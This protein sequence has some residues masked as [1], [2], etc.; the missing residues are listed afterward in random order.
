ME[1]DPKPVLLEG[2]HVRM[3]PLTPEH[4]AGLFAAA[5]LEVFRYLIIPP[6]GSVADADAYV[7]AAL[8]AQAKGTEVPFATVRR[9]DG[10]VVGTTRF[11]DI[12]R[13]HR[14]LE[15]GWTWITPAAQRTP[16][17]TEAK[18]LM[19][20]QAFDGWGALRVQL[21]TDENNARSRAAI[22]RIGAKFEGVLR[23]QML[24]AHDGY[25]RN[26][27]MFSITDDEWPAAKAKLAAMLER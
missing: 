13:P 21:K 19:L 17:N 18:Y 7:A 27:A 15:I 23:K 3:E 2:R 22:Q 9:S 12:Q 26:T 5:T 6:F 20:C 14:T 25:Q 8:A 11:L 16:V 4:A 10:V 1:F 24:R